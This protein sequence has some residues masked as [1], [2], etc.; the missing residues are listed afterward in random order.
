MDRQ[1]AAEM[2]RVLCRLREDRP[3]IQCFA[4]YVSMD[5]MANALLAIGA[6]PAMVHSE[7]ESVEF[8]HLAAGG[9]ARM[10]PSYSLRACLQAQ[11]DQ[12]LPLVCAYLSARLAGLSI[13]I[14]T[15]SP[16]WVESMKKAAGTANVQSK[17]WVFDPVGCGAT[18]Y[19]TT[20]STEILRLQ[21]TVVRGNAS[22]I[23]CLAGQSA[24]VRGVDST[25]NSSSQVLSAQ[26]IAR[27]H[28]CVVV[29]TGEVDYISDGNTT[30]QVTNGVPMLQSVT[31]TGCSLSSIVCAFVAS[32]RAEGGLRIRPTPG[33]AG[34]DP[35]RLAGV[36]DVRS[37]AYA[38]AAFGVCAE[39]AS[40]ESRGPGSFRAA[41]LD[42]LY[43]LSEEHVLKMAKVVLV[44][45]VCASDVGTTETRVRCHAD[46]TFQSPIQ[47]SHN[48]S[49]KESHGKDSNPQVLYA[50]PKSTDE[51][52]PSSLRNRVTSL[53]ASLATGAWKD[54]RI[55]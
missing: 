10:S 54:Y 5:I 24:T 12:P 3:L 15:L 35:I 36:P 46:A 50:N 29:V 40:Q 1:L 30:L 6:S 21:P 28:Q 38:C 33:I 31:A 34:D 47:W 49:T 2:W 16:D 4:N 22:E 48:E 13:N 52:I 44:E 55:G 45:P 23:G 39:L 17:P 53:W 11:R 9:P 42:H 7:K 19:R 18:S 43:L 20:T 14:G 27:S 51:S 8:V 37:A 41:L 26:E 25:L 32:G